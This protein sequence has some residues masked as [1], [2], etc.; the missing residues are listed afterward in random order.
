M[1]HYTVLAGF[2]FHLGPR[3]HLW[4]CYTFAFTREAPPFPPETALGALP[5]LHRHV[6]HH[7]YHLTRDVAVTLVLAEIHACHI[8][9]LLYS[10]QVRYGSG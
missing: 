9:L 8:Q 2:T 7:A 6:G 1:N 4:C 10:Y 5:R 3:K